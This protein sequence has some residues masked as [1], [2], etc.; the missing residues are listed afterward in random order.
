MSTILARLAALERSR[1]TDALPAPALVQ[2]IGPH[3][4]TPEQVVAAAV[5]EKN[6]TQIFK[7]VF[8]DARQPA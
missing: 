2:V 4:P 8:K 7:I 6:G 5:A 1:E 3:G